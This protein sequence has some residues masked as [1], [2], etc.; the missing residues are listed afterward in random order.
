ME[1]R[2]LIHQSLLLTAVVLLVAACGAAEPTATPIPP[3]PT[4]IPPTVTPA[5]PPEPVTTETSII[6]RSIPYV[7]GGDFQQNLTLY[8]PL[9]AAA[10][11]GPYPVLV[12]AHG[13][14]LSK[15]DYALKDTM[16]FVNQLG[17]AAVSIDYRDDENGSAWKAH[18]DGACALA[19]I[20][21][22]A[23]EYGLDTERMAAFGN[24]YG[25]MVVTNLALADDPSLFLADCPN[26]RPEARPFKGVV[27]FGAGA[28]GVPGE[29]L[30]I[31]T[32]AEALSPQTRL[33]F[34]FETLEGMKAVHEELA[35][36]PPSEWAASQE[37][38]PEAVAF[39]Q[40]QPAYWA[41][42]GDPPLLL[43]YPEEDQFWPQAEYD[44]FA[45]LLEEVGAAYTYLVLPGADHSNWNRDDPAGWQEPLREFL[46]GLFGG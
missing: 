24:S 23:E 3:T 36:L 44:A 37:L 2:K 14:S 19:W 22:N 35:A 27:P 5:A 17:Y 43:L 25:A 18:H 39:A 6:H 7:P 29:G 20:Y 31:P 21:A 8:L 41:D 45:R 30:S 46:E 1:L 32:R 26:G 38:S 16:Q 42:A 11:S 13:W 40:L 10:G 15:T 33:L 9:E 28:F 4:S 12:L 34:G